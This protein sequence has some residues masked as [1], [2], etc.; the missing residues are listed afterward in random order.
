[1]MEKLTKE[2]YRKDLLATLDNTIQRLFIEMEPIN[3]DKVKWVNGKLLKNIK[4]HVGVIFD[5]HNALLNAN[6]VENGD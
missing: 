2:Q 1:M 6:E 3:N 5:C 4:R